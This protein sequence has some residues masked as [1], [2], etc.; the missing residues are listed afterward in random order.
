MRQQRS[1]VIAQFGSIGS[2][3]GAAAGGIYCSTK[4]AM[5]GVTESLYYELAPLGISVCCIEP[6]YFR[7]GFLNPGARVQTEARIKDYDETAV[8]EVRKMFEERNNKQL[9]DI[10]K[11]C[12]VLFDVLTKRS[13]K[14]IPIRLTLGSDAYTT[15]IGKC[16]ETK[17][18]LEEWKGVIQ[19]TDHEEKFY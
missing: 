12:A 10:E 15:I 3:H 1:G 11:G 8:G 16:D 2:W 14:E 9:G 18:L 6:G 19:S 5:S 17:K 7:T 13:G 4:W